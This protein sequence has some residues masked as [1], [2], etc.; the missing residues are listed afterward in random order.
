MARAPSTRSKPGTAV[1][2]WEKEMEAQANA[3]VQME[4]KSGGGQ[5]FSVKGGQLSFDGAPLPGNR[6]AVVVVD[7]IIEY[8]YY[9][10][11]YDP[12]NPDSPVCF[13]FGRDEDTIR[14]HENSLPEYAGQLCK[15]SDINQWGSAD[16]GRGKAAKNSR[17]LAII[18][19]GVYDA[20]GNLTLFDDE[21]HFRK[22]P[23]AFMKL[24]TTSINGWAAYVK[25]VAGTLKRPPHGIFTEISVIPDQKTQFRVVFEG[26][27]K[28]SN[29]LIKVM[30]DRNKEAMAIEPAPYE[31]FEKQPEQPKRGA[32]SAAGTRAPAGRGMAKAPAKRKY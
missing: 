24:P 13:A 30:M 29:D 7:S 25:Q 14:W 28:V 17:R 32:K 11:R 23:I 15:D 18:P 16:T 27:E 9:E 31:K 1:V 10:G 22:T 20:K 4:R 8:L 19:A 26:I 3:A 2:D 21:D 5:F 6:V 12:D